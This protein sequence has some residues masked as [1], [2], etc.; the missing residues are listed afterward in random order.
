MAYRYYLP[1]GS[2]V[3][4]PDNIPVDVAEAKARERFPDR[5]KQQE[6]PESGS[7]AKGAFARGAERGVLPGLAG[8]VGGRLAGAAASWLLGPEVG[9][10]VT[11]ASLIGGLGAGTAGSAAQEKALQAAPEFAKRIGQDEE[12]QRADLAAHPYAAATGEGLGSLVGMKPNLSLLG[13]AATRGPA[14][15]KMGVNAAIGAGIDTGFQLY[16][17]QPYDPIQTLIAGGVGGLGAEENRLGRGAAALGEAPINLM[18]GRGAFPKVE[19]TVKPPSPKEEAKE[20]KK[21]EAARQRDT[22]RVQSEGKGVDIA[23]LLVGERKIPPPVGQAEPTRVPPPDIGEEPPPGYGE[24]MPPPVSETPAPV[25]PPAPPAEAVAPAPEPPPPEPPPSEPPPLSD[26]ERALAGNTGEPGVT[27]HAEPSGA[28]PGEGQIRLDSPEY[29]AATEEDHAA[30]VEALKN[31]KYVVREGFKK[32]RRRPADSVFHVVDTLEQAN[33]LVEQLN[34]KTSEK[35]TDVKIIEPP[36]VL[37]AEA[38]NRRQLESRW[39]DPKEDIKLLKRATRDANFI[40]YAAKFLANPD[41]QNKLEEIKLRYENAGN[42]EEA[43]KILR[44]L[45]GKPLSEEEAQ[46]RLELLASVKRQF[47]G[48]LGSSITMNKHVLNRAE[49]IS[50]PELVEALSNIERR[51]AEI[52]EEQEGKKR[53]PT[54]ARKEVVDEEKP[55]PEDLPERF[56]QGAHHPDWM[57]EKVPP[58]PAAPPETRSAAEINA[59]LRANREQYIRERNILKDEPEY[60]EP[61]SQ[62]ERLEQQ[63]TEPKH[64]LDSLHA[65]LKDTFGIHTRRLIDNGFLNILPD[66]SALP[67]GISAGPY[68]RGIYSVARNK[69]YLM[70]N[71]IPRDYNLKGLLLHEIGTHAGMETM[72]GKSLFQKLLKE[73][74]LRAAHGDKPFVEADNAVRS[75][76]ISSEHE[77]EERLAYLVSKYKDLP[78]VKRIYSQ[79]REFLWRAMGGRFITLSDEDIGAMA[80]TSLRRVGRLA[81]AGRT[82]ELR[83]SVTGNLPEEEALRPPTPEEQNA[84]DQRDMTRDEEKKLNRGKLMGKLKEWGEALKDRPYREAVKAF[85]NTQRLLEEHDIKERAIGNLAPGEAGLNDLATLRPSSLLKADVNPHVKAVTDA[86]DRYLRVTKQSAAE[87]LASFKRWMIGLTEKDLRKYLYSRFVPLDETPRVFPGQ[88]E[89]ISAAALREALVKAHETV[90]DLTS[91]DALQKH[92]YDAKS[93]RDYVDY[94]AENFATRNGFTPE[95]APPNVHT[96]RGDV[97]ITSIDHPAYD[98][99]G[100]VTREQAERWRNELQKELAGPNGKAIQD[101]LDTEKALR[102]KIRDVEVQNGHWGQHVDNAIAFQNREHY[103]TLKGDTGRYNFS[104]SPGTHLRGELGKAQAELGGR[105]T[106]ADN[107]LT[108][109]IADAN[110]ALSRF[111]KKRFLDKL[112]ELVQTRQLKDQDHKAVGKM[113]DPITVGNR[114]NYELPEGVTADQ[115]VLRPNDKGGYDVMQIENKEWREAIKGVTNTQS[116][117]LSFLGKATRAITA[118]VTRY[119]PGFAPINAVRHLGT[120][121]GNLASELGFTTGL[122]VASRFVTQMAAGSPFKA[123]YAAHLIATDNIA[124]LKQLATKD[125]FYRNI[126]DWD[127]EGGKITF[128]MAYSNETASK[129]L[130]EELGKNGMLAKTKGAI[131]HIAD[132]WNNTFE[133][134]NREAAFDTLKK[135]F[136]EQGASPDEVNTRAAAETKRLLNLELTGRHSKDMASWFGLFKAEATGAVRQ[137]DAILAPLFQS[138]DDWIRSNYGTKHQRDTNAPIERILWNKEEREAAVAHWQERRK[139]AYLMTV[140]AMGFGYAMHKMARGVAEQDE[141]GRNTVGT[142]DYAQWVRNLRVPTTILGPLKDSLGKDNKFIN[143]PWGFGTGAF[144]SIGA[145]L[146]ALEEGDVKPLQAAQH[147]ISAAK[148]SFMPVPLE[149]WGLFNRNP[150]GWAV[151]SA[152]PTPLKPILYYAW[153]ADSFGRQIYNT[154]IG[155]YGEA[156]AGGDY[157]PEMF[158]SLSQALLKAT[159]GAVDLNPHTLQFFANNY[160]QGIANVTQAIVGNYENVM[161]EKDFDMKTDMPIFSSLVGRQTDADARDFADTEAALQKVKARLSTLKNTGNDE[162]YE[163]YTDKNPDAEWMVKRYDRIKAHINKINKEMNKA[164]A[165]GESPK[166]IREQTD[167]LRK[168]RSSYMKDLNDDY[169][170]NKGTI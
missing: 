67:E 138:S 165:T 112:F 39:A 19:P 85:Q 6:A 159:D 147:M 162:A 149:D 50:D 168:I 126:L 133:F 52:K 142:D 94:L 157:V 80:A 47:I 120:N 44:D 151:A 2:S 7:S 33:A 59:E 128:N 99:A 158:K 139:N 71:G 167:D 134:M 83:R 16:N 37:Q 136:I 29:P 150:A 121:I 53:Q 61:V 113:L 96:Y 104:M 60:L 124:K 79:I 111:D 170:E 109:T 3:A 9:F 103:Y 114:R 42:S 76:S 62:E 49:A 131:N 64:D 98:L 84:A 137:T 26:T 164:R 10:F 24:E 132:V 74:E 5:F 23:A 166:D 169:A 4:V 20:E 93:L 68:T 32:F 155:K 45:T 11:G 116:M 40:K 35:P 140:A 81:E 130:V 17:G 66:R 118:G 73:V 90:K 63:A 48:D 21:V 22:E 146:S 36:S 108:Q 161:G 101:V 87:G 152:A 57:P 69:V 143:I 106:M 91:A 1:D 8:L 102:A 135:K 15:A 27:P 55:T 89:P 92:G 86:F 129:A 82:E 28:Q 163:R 75:R 127:T 30:A 43:V 145:Q 54:P 110:V 119:N 123:A 38:E 41:I 65:A 156:Y 160:A 51:K 100:D 18:R 72:L 141:E 34:D 107:P 58:A 154:R 105:T 12:T 95:H 115:I 13:N 14:L 144:A 125:S 97:N 122:R 46:K 78:F 117:P 25:P 31:G 148:E 70:A 153:N 88:A 77:G 56:E